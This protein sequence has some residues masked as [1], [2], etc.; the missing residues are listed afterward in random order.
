MT[1]P[2][3][4]GI[5]ACHECDH[6]HRVKP[7]S[8][9][10]KA[11]C[12]KCGNLLYRQ[13]SNS[14]DKSLALYLAAF[15]LMVIANSFPFLSLQIGGRAEHNVLVSGAIALHQLGMSELGLL[16]FLTSVFFPSRLD[17]IQILWMD[18]IA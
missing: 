10:A 9:G 13:V 1:A 6:L 12:T 4:S 11:L 5:V 8:E 15:V 2:A 16:V 3:Q 17:M 18:Q 14:V 7:I